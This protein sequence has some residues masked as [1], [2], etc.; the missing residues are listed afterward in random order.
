MKKRIDSHHNLSIRYDKTRQ[1]FILDARVIGGGQIPF[2]TKAEAT[3]KAKDLFLKFKEGEP[4]SVGAEWTVKGAV[5]RFIAMSQNRL[6]DAQDKYGP[7]T[8]AQQ[9]AQLDKICK[10]KLDGL[11]LGKRKVKH[12]DPDL[13]VNHL[14]P[15][16]KKIV[17]SDMT[18]SN[19]YVSFK[20]VLSYC[21]D[22][23]QIA[24]NVAR[25]AMS[26]TRKPRVILPSKVRRAIKK[27]REDVPKVS[28]DT[29]QRIMS[30]VEGHK[31]RL[32]LLTA[33]Q[34]G[35]RVGE[36]VMVR[37]YQKK[38]HNKGGLDFEG[39][40]IWVFE[41]LKR[42]AKSSENY[43]GPPKSE[44]GIRRVPIS[45]ALCLQ[46]EEYWLALP[47][48]EKTEGW[49]FPTKHGTRSDTNNWR[50]HIL[51]KACDKAGLN[52]EERPTFHMLRHCYATALLSTQ[53]ADFVKCMEKMGHADISTTMLYKHI[54]VR[55]E[56]EKSETEAI[57]DFYNISV[58]E[59]KKEPTTNV[60][61][62]EKK[63]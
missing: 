23:K 57:A 10:L 15:S 55:P 44:S 45:P 4:T 28:P 16:L 59:P 13:M 1:R 5:K 48:K 33:M 60:I 58:D 50:N 20:T 27:L 9:Q 49:L 56:D 8:F 7:A 42:G 47:T 36:L 21:V 6:H 46:L 25:D 3:A 39:N 29:I 38:Y 24:S 61:K 14:W 19:Y 35:L 40:A 62:L 54:I 52:K 41:A 30:E 17:P 26:R 32:I 22:Q 37:I 43:V 63:S 2:A 51:Y 53:G 34:T 31:E 11:E 18:A 12:L